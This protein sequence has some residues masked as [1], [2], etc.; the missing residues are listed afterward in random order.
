MAQCYV[1]VGSNID[2]AKNIDAGLN[3]LREM[4][5]ELNVSPIYETA[6]I[7]FDGD[8]F[9]NLVV[10][11]ES[12]LS[13]HAVFQI[14][15]DLE[16][17]HGRLLNSQKFSPRSLDL[18]LLLYG[19]EIIEDDVL[20]LPRVDIE[21]YVFVLQ[22]LADIAPDLIHPIHQKTYRKMLESLLSQSPQ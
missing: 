3:S 21:K 11:F 8:D 6:A 7:G 15:R 5:G 12:D 9:Y 13:A 17:K 18:D 1:S 2:K 22:P 4:F 14:L 19:D 16:F 20:K 10:G